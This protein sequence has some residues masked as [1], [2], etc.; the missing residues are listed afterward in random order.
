MRFLI[1]CWAPPSL[2]EFW[3]YFN[4]EWFLFLCFFG[5]AMLIFMTSSSCLLVVVVL[6]M[7][8][9]KDDF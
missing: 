2:P 8:L 7:A 5:F 9:T 1:G 3:F 6:S 4:S